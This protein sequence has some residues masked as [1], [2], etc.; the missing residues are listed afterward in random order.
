M[1]LLL[2]LQLANLEQELLG[3]LEAGLEAGLSFLLHAS[4]CQW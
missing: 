3:G 1:R 2:L 4:S